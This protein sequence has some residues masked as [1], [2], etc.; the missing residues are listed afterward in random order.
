MVVFLNVT[1]NRMQIL[2]RMD[3]G[4]IELVDPQPA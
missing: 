3:A 2:R 4:A 1:S